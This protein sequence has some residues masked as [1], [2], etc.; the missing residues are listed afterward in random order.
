GDELRRRPLEPRE[1][2]PD[3]DDRQSLEDG[4]P[5]RVVVLRR[6][7]ELV[8]DVDV[9][10]D[11]ERRELG[12]RVARDV[13]LERTVE[14]EDARRRI[15]DGSAL[16]ADHRLGE[17]HV[18]P[19]AL[20]GAEHPAGGDQHRHSCRLRPRDR[21]PGAVAH[22]P[23]G[24]DQ[25]P[26]EVAGERLHLR[27][28]VRKEAQPPVAEETNA[29]TSAIC[30][31]CSW[32]LKDGTPPWPSVTRWTTSSS[33]GL[34]SPR[35]CRSVP[36]AFASDSVW[37]AA[38]PALAKTSLPAAASPSSARAG[39]SSFAP[40]VVSSGTV[41][42]TVSRVA[43][44]SSPP[45]TGET[46]E[47]TASRSAR[48]ASGRRIARSLTRCVR[49]PRADPSSKRRITNAATAPNPITSP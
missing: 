5:A 20:D 8:V 11:A 27:G 41:P 2:V 7:V 6:D 33:D 3:G 12:D 45:H 30:C 13:E 43:V 28:E 14:Q 38:Q 4:V 18:V 49:A 21:G 16:V 1:Q 31:G 9:R 15:H 36:D 23:V 19:V 48:A 40:V 47:N 44:T 35:F 34:A 26:V 46:R 10:G 29:A 25:R 24:R 32:S 37:Q 17:A 42:T 22:E 39:R